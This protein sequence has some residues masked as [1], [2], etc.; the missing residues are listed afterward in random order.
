RSLGRSRDRGIRAA[1]R[2]P[3]MAGS[4]GIGHRIGLLHGGLLRQVWR[5]DPPARASSIVAVAEDKQKSKPPRES[6]LA[7]TGNRLRDAAGLGRLAVEEPRAV[8][9]EL[10]RRFKRFLRTLWNSHGGGLYACGFVI[11]F[12]WLEASTI[13]GEFA[14]S[15]S[16]ASFVAVELIEFVFRFSVQSLVNTILAFI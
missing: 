13:V 15:S 9:G 14:S 12:L 10:R 8:P 5:L 16:F 7:R 1:C 11:A 3:A 2:A 4:N 6:F